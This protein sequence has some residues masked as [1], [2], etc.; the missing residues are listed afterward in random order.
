M[1]Q[2]LEKGASEAAYLQYLMWFRRLK[3]DPVH[4]EVMKTPHVASWKKKKVWIMK[5]PRTQPWIGQN[6]LFNRIFQPRPVPK[7][8]EEEEEEE[9]KEEKEEEDD[10][11]DKES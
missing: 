10:E 2:L 4:E 7:N 6:F 3:R 9:E 11:D 8:E 5:R 1:E